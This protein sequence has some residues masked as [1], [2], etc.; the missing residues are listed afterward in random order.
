VRRGGFAVMPALGGH[1]V[2]RAVHEPP[3]IPNYADPRDHTILTDGLVIAVEPI[4]CAGSGRMSEDAD[5]WTI[6]TADRTLAAHHEH[7]V[8]VT[9]RGPLVLTSI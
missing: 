7:T 1:G 5:G 8:V 6:R 9:E 4:I 2:G 3:S